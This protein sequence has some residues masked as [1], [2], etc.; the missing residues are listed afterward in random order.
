[1]TIVNLFDRITLGL[2]AALPV[3]AFLFVAPS[4]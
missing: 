1:M 4:L 2:V 3:A